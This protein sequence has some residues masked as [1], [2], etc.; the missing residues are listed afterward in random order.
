MIDLTQMTD[1][2]LREYELSLMQYTQQEI[3]YAA[4]VSQDKIYDIS[5]QY[6]DRVTE[7]QESYTKQKNRIRLELGLRIHPTCP[8]RLHNSWELPQ[9]GKL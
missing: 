4:I 1:V 3:D 8:A 2:E 9:E 5:Q 6:L 7:I